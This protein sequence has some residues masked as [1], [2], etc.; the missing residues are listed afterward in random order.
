MLVTA[1]AGLSSI[2]TSISGWLTTR[3]ST[4]THAARPTAAAR[5]RPMTEA[6]PQP[7]DSPSDT[8]SSSAASQPQTSRA[9]PSVVHPAGLVHHRVGRHEEQHADQAEHRQDQAQQEDVLVAAVFHHPAGADQAEARADA[10]RGGD[11]RDRADDALARQLVPDDRDGQR[12]DAA[13]EALQHPGDE[14]HRPAVHGGGQQRAEDQPAHRDDQDL[15]PAEQVAAAAEQRGED[16]GG[17]QVRGHHPGHAA[18][19]DPVVVPAEG[20][21]GSAPTEVWITGEGEHRQGECAASTPVVP[22]AIRAFGADGGSGGRPPTAGGGRCRPGRR[23]IGY[24]RR[25]SVGASRVAATPCD[26]GV[27]RCS[28]HWPGPSVSASVSG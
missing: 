17:Q 25:G 3:R 28:G 1:T 21:A 19:G 10:Q 24:G 22:G 9:V 15:A 16:R 20:R 14:Q 8:A 27:A 4:R 12:Q 11:Q 5:N 26:Q 18:G 13:A 23:F 6:E 2:E 7:Q